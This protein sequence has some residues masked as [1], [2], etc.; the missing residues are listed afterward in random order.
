MSKLKQEIDSSIEELTKVKTVMLRGT[1]NYSMR[2]T[3][4]GDSLIFIMTPNIIISSKDSQLMADTCEIL[5]VKQIDEITK[6]FKENHNKYEKFSL[7]LKAGDLF[8]QELIEMM[9]K[10]EE[11]RT[12]I[13]EKG[14]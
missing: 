9:Q 8:T 12:K 11:E 5:E 1:N 7:N 13:K 14:K 6:Y 3:S 4:E 10:R 2:V